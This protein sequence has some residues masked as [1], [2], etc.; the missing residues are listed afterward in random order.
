M[1]QVLIVHPTLSPNFGRGGADTVLVSYLK[2]FSEFVKQGKMKVDLLLFVEAIYDDIKDIPE[3]INIHFESRPLGRAEAEFQ[4]YCQMKLGHQIS[5]WE[6]DYFNSWDDYI[7]NFTNQRI[8][9][10]LNQAPGE[11][12]HYYDIIINFDQAMDR[13]LRDYNISDQV[14][15]I[16]WIHSAY[17]GENYLNRRDEWQ[18]LL[19]KHQ[20]FISICPEMKEY[21]DEVFY[22]I[23]VNKKH[24]TLFNPINTQI[25]LEKANTQEIS[26]EDKALLNQNYILQVG[27]LFDYKNNEAMIEIYAQLKQKGIQEKLYIIG[28]GPQGESLQER[29]NSLGLQE[30]CL[31][32]GHKDNPFV[33]MKHAKLFTHTSRA[34]GLAMVL[35]ESMICGTPVVSMDCPVGP[36]DVLENGKYGALV[37]LD[38][39]AQFADVV[40]ELLTHEEKRQAYI[41]KLPEAI[42]RFE[43]DTISEQLEQILNEAYHNRAP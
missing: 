4:I 17:H 24:V 36:K 11:K 43:F 37:P 34:E 30:D 22:Q 10:V 9:S 32:L 6:R 13:F 8:L 28:N 15:I 21:Y 20:T 19:N 35:L 23:G 14:A 16:R 31:L 29:I 7:H 33:F 25:I 40:Y 2:I 41:E 18:P 12:K 42:H 5:D 39:N 1:K 3:N 38:D 27:R 26:E